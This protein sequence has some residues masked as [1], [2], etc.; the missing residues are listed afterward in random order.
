M[1]FFKRRERILVA[2]CAV[3]V[4]LAGAAGCG[5]QIP[6]TAEGKV[7]RVGSK[8]PMPAADAAV[9]KAAGIEAD[10]YSLGVTDRDGVSVRRY[11]PVRGVDARQIALKASAAID[12]LAARFPSLTL[13]DVVSTL[14]SPTS[15]EAYDLGKRGVYFSAL[16]GNAD[17]FLR[18][19]SGAVTEIRFESGDRPAAP[20]P[21][22][23]RNALGIGSRLEDVYAL[24]GQ[25]VATIEFEA[26]PLDRDR[27]LQVAK[28][29]SVSYIK[30]M[31]EGVRFF[32]S[33]DI[34]EAMYLFKP[35]VA[36]A[37]AGKAAPAPTAA[38]PVP[39]AGS[40]PPAIP[41]AQGATKPFD[42]V[43]DLRLPVESSPRDAALMRTLWFSSSTVFAGPSA[44]I[45]DSVLEAGRNPGL[46]TRALHEEGVTG[47]GVLVGIIDQNLP[48][49]GHPEYAGKVVAYRDFGTAMSAGSGSMHG[50]AVLSLLVGDRAGTAPG[51]RVYFAAAPSWSGDAKYYAE[52]LDWLVEESGKLPRGKGI[53]VVSVSAAPSGQ[54]S[55]FSKN[56]PEWDRA[57]ERAAAK[58]I[59]VLDCTTQRGRIGACFYDPADP[60]DPRACIPGWP[61]RALG[62]SS[63]GLL[64]PTSY[65]SYAEAYSASSTAWQYTGKGGLSWGIPWAAGVL[66][67][68]WQLD[69]SLKAEEIMKLLGDSACV[70]PEGARIIDP[71]AFV[72]TVKRGRR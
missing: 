2:A 57:V 31:S 23:F 41:A 32:A 36:P 15:F 11:T 39:A 54:G 28:N 48:G 50:P 20:A 72:E 5:S 33:S 58:G 43:R 42:D 70:S 27:A 7:Y 24:L 34:V 29:R 35:S 71:R 65:R 25:P 56:G 12:S 30:Y 59:L 4:V 16:Y 45:A 67:M 19:G 61:D 55:P 17:F 63:S 13:R 66:A 21:Y 44:T 8:S 38:T 68:G 1:I 10:A 52:A 26:A 3:A 64:A 18:D 40:A 14:G 51:A 47:A 37:A 69:P 46:G 49:T 53:R 9:M 60:E 22:R 6:G 62:F